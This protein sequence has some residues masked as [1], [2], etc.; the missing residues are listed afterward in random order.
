MKCISCGC[1]LSNMGYEDMDHGVHFIR[2]S[3][4][5]RLRN[6]NSFVLS[7]SCVENPLFCPFFIFFSSKASSPS[8]RVNFLWPLFKFHNI[9]IF[10]RLYVFF[11]EE[12][13]C[14]SV[15]PHVSIAHTMGMR[16]F[17]ENQRHSFYIIFSH[18]YVMIILV[19]V[20]H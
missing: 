13:H 10:L 5:R 12:M 3:R 8:F 11:P 6:F 4:W 18:G 20:N 7:G 16:H 15:P 1:W 17:L 9:P 19:I 2:F 14:S